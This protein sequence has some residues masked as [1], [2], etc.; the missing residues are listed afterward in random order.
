M[1]EAAKAAAAAGLPSSDSGDAH[2][3]LGK[4]PAEALVEDAPR[5]P[6]LRGQAAAAADLAAAPAS[7]LAELGGARACGGGIEDSRISLQQVDQP[8]VPTRLFAN[9]LLCSSVSAQYGTICPSISILTF[10]RVHLV[11]C[12]HWHAFAS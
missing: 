1:Q 8:I 2:S 11:I 6:F 4:R 3:P 5:A 7:R 9:T 12:P 10:A